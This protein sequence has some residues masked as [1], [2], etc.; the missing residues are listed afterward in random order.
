M[1][2]R[3]C[4]APGETVVSPTMA[5]AMHG[6]ATLEPVKD[7][8]P[9]RQFYRLLPHADDLVKIAHERRQ[10]SHVGAEEQAPNGHAEEEE[11]ERIHKIADWKVDPP[12]PL[13]P[14]EVDADDVDLLRR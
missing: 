8:P 14:I 2:V 9:G 1:P 4:C 5:D 7:S 6:V 10:G 13:A 11:L 12:P 3:V